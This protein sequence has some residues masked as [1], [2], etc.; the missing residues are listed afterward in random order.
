MIT[1]AN[2]KIPKT[3]KECAKALST[4]GLAFDPRKPPNINKKNFLM[5]LK[6][7]KVKKGFFELPTTSGLVAQ[8]TSC[9]PLAGVQKGTD[10]ASSRTPPLQTR[11]GGPFIQQSR[12]LDPQRDVLNILYLDPFIFLNLRDVHHPPNV[13]GGHEGCLLL[14][15]PPKVSP[16]QIKKKITCN[17]PM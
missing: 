15:K 9:L 8:K 4:K 13:P 2:S 3:Q 5:I 16:P 12:T 11:F 14:L 17:R 7:Y 1:D 10:E 6:R